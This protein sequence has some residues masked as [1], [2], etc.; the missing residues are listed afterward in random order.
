VTAWSR[1]SVLEA[2]SDVTSGNAKV[3]ATGYLPEGRFPIIDQG[4]ADV[5]GYTDDEGLVCRVPVPVI[6]FGDHTRTLKYVDHPFVL[7]ADGVK[8]LAPQ[9]GWDPRYLYRALE[10]I[11]IPSAGYSRHFKFLK[12]RSLPRPPMEEQRRIAAILDQ[13][14]ATRAGFGRSLAHVDDLVVSCFWDLFDA[15]S[16]PFR[17]WPRVPIGDAGDV[18]LGR[19]RGPQYQTGRCPRP[20]MRVANVQMNAVKFDDVLEM[21]FDDRDFAKFRLRW[22]DVLLNEGQVTEWVG[23]PAMWRDEI[24]DC[25]F[26]NSLIRF[27]PRDGLVESEFALYLFMNYVQG[28]VFARASSKTSNV[29]HLSAS[30]FARLSF[31]LPPI[32]LQREFATVVRAAREQA[33]RLERGEHLARELSASLRDG[34]FKGEL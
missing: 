18:L 24:A 11:D 34:A 9:A 10:A 23:R 17:L 3:P 8:V 30:R 19:Q 7:G 13:A 1:V 22:G 5:A 33:G 6:L 4:Q 21:D 14:E 2:V 20:Y 15:H 31:V 16:A 32:S 26:Q 27:R 25:C 28:G 29:A 12:E